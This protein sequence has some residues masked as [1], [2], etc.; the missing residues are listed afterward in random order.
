MSKNENCVVTD[1]AICKWIGKDCKDCYLAEM[2]D[3]A[4]SKKALGEFEVMLSLL[5]D[6]LDNLQSDDCCFCKGAPKK[7]SCYAIIDLAHKDPES[8]RGMFFGMGKKVRQ[9]IGSILPISISMC[10]ECRRNYRGAETI[11]WLTI[12]VL[13]GI[14]LGVCFIPAVNANQVVPYAVILGSFLVGYILGKIFSGMYVNKKSA[15]TRFNVFDI[16]VC[17]QMKHDG[18]FTIQDES[19][20]T[21]FIF[22]RKP[23]IKKLSDVGIKRD[24]SRET[25]NTD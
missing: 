4:E 22:S 12:L 8:K 25:F 19:L 1:S 11:K 21:H 17:A 3:D 15:V 6:E 16:P 5:P 20:V 18:W 9:R 13:A 7:R 23:M 24:K 2:K 14:G 10:G